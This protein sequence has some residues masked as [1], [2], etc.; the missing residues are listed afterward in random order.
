LDRQRLHLVSA[1]K[2]TPAVLFEAGIASSYLSWARVIPGIATFT[3]TCA[4]DR[5]GLGWSDPAR[6]PRTVAGM[7]GDLRGV[8]AHA[9]TA[10][11]APWVLVGHSFG[12]FLV[13]AYA[14]AHPADVA[15]LVL[16]D[17]PSDWHRVTRRQARLLWGGIQLSRIGGILARIGVVRAGLALLT[18][19]APG[20][21][22][23]MVRIFG[24]TTARTLERLVG[25]VRKLP[26]EVHPIVQALWS[27][28]KC[29]RAMAEHLG[30]LQDMAA[31]VAGVTSLPD[32]PIVVVSSGD[33]S[34]ET[35]ARHR[36]LARLS[37]SG[38]HV[39]AEKAGHWIQLD[40]PE[41]V[42]TTIRDVWKSARSA[43]QRVD[44][45]D[46]RGAPGWN[47]AGDGGNGCE[48]EP[49]HHEGRR[50]RRRHAEEEAGEILTG[51]ARDEEADREAR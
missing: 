18:K 42:I 36:A 48:G 9:K 16:L 2:G 30:A 4:Y 23:R 38:R 26:P 50:I 46:L 27:Q 20:V 35:I 5:A 31:A 25:E 8:I 37:P 41:L 39:I 32:V 40:D 11:G 24:S 43:P 15:G 34:R 21:P 12:A 44:R 3:G 17:P 19:G 29:F 49:D 6:G 1:G 51:P 33:Q 14:S 45:I 47:A 7:L 10:T 28:P 13:Y 22:K